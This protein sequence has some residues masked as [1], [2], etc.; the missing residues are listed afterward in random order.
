FT[1]SRSHDRGEVLGLQA[2]SAHQGAVD[3]RLP[4]ELGGIVRFD[5]AAILDTPTRGGVLSEQPPDLCADVPADPIRLLRRAY[6]SRSDRPTRLVGE[7]DRSGLAG[8]QAREPPLDL[9]RHDRIGTAV[10]ALAQ[11]LAAAYDGGE[12]VRQSGVRLQVDAGI[13]LTKGCEQL[14]CPLRV[15]SA[16]A[17]TR[18]RVPEDHG[19]TPHVPEHGGR[20]LAGVSAALLPEHPLRPQLD[21]APLQC[22][23]RRTERGKRW[24]HD[25]V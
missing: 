21:A 10:P 16:E 18:L 19:A 12:A 3:L 8:C 5:A 11:Q 20:D 4:Q 25:D 9:S 23:R 7:H 1:W 2:R 15:R 24:A 17:P 14:R 6:L 13:A 22:L